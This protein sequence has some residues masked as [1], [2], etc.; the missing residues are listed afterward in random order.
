MFPIIMSSTSTTVAASNVVLRLSEAEESAEVLSRGCFVE[1]P[2]VAKDFAVPVFL[3]GDQAEWTKAVDGGM[4]VDAKAKIA[5]A[6]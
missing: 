1:R 5:V 2:R 3:E 6:A 4:L